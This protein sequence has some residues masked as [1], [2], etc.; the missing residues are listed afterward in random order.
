MLADDSGDPKGYLDFLTC[1]CRHLLLVP[2]AEGE[3]VFVAHVH[4][5]QGE[6]FPDVANPVS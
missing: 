5:A 2:E 4:L 3:R 1:K 6:A